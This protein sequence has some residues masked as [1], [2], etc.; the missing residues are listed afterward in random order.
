MKYLKCAVALCCNGED[1]PLWGSILFCEKPWGVH[2][3]HLVSLIFTCPYSKNIELFVSSLAAGEKR[4][5]SLS[6]SWLRDLPV[7]CA[8]HHINQ[9]EMKALART[10]NC[11]L[12]RWF[13]RAVSSPCCVHGQDRQVCQPELEMWMVGGLFVVVVV[14]NLMCHLEQHEG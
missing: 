4:V 11:D 5:S 14:V 9:C 1:P 2:I 7:L 6:S 3:A 8:H 10:I 13:G 12:C